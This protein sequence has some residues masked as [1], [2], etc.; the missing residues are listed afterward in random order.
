MGI[1]L[2]ENATI[3]RGLIM[4]ADASGSSFIRSSGAE[5][6]TV[7]NGFFMSSSGN[8]RFGNP[9]TNI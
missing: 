3:T 5:S 2:A 6:L 9:T 4:G 7:G 1:L 8:F